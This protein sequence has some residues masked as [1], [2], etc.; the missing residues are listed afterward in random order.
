MDD[1]PDAPPATTAASDFTLAPAPALV[2]VEPSKQEVVATRIGQ[3]APTE[4]P[5]PH[6]EKDVDLNIQQEPDTDPAMASDPPP[7]ARPR[8]APVFQNTFAWLDDFQD[9]EPE[10]SPGFG[11]I[12]IAP[13]PVE[14]AEREERSPSPLGRRQFYHSKSRQPE[15]T[16]APSSLSRDACAQSGDV[17]DT[18][19]SYGERYTRGWWVLMLD[20]NGERQWRFR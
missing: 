19:Y 7:P 1:E 5:E 20:A 12:V 2:A 10:V 6:A 16:S 15:L 17:L 4:T 9:D 3:V 11:D 18:Q 14:L 8:R 13:R